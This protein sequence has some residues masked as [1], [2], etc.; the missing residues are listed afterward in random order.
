MAAELP[1][2]RSGAVR[3]A[4]SVVVDVDVATAAD[5]DALPR[6]G[7]AMAARI[8]ANRDSFGPFGS[9]AALR[10]VKGMGPATLERLSPRVTFSGRAASITAG[11]RH[12]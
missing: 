12:H 6:V 5:L 7:A 11:N 10:R 9:L 2:R 3:H 8:V 4:D 1:D